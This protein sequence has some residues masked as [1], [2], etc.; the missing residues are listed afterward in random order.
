[1]TSI[2]LF[3]T[4]ANFFVMGGLGNGKDIILRCCSQSTPKREE[5]KQAHPCMG[6]DVQAEHVHTDFIGVN[7]LTKD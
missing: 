1:M 6:A 3:D 7:V 2:F 4:P 5:R